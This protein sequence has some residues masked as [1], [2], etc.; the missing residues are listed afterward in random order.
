MGVQEHASAESERYGDGQAPL[1]SYAAFVGAYNATFA[2]ALLCARI[3]GRTL[4]TPSLGDIA[5]FGVATHKLSRLLAKDKVTA[6][7]R[8]PFAEY[9]EDGG[10]AEVE[11]RPRGQG[12]RRAVGELVTCPYCLDQWVA[13]GFAVA[14]IFAP[15]TT[16]LTAGVFATVAV[17]DFLQIAYKLGH[18][19]L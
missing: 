19:T 1:D 14:A 7:L 6:L 10:P 17:A 11:E 5:L 9:K 8:A 18:R 2:A 13:G 4:P 12:A 16:R 3:A 15:R